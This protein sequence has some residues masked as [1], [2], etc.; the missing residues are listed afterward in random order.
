MK[1]K[2]EN[3]DLK[4]EWDYQRAKLLLELSAVGGEENL[5]AEQVKTLEKEVTLFLWREIKKQFPAIEKFCTDRKGQFNKC[6]KEHYNTP[7]ISIYGNFYMQLIAE[8]NKNAWVWESVE[9]EPYRFYFNETD[10][11]KKQVL[12]AM[13]NLIVNGEAKKSNFS[14]LIKAMDKETIKEEVIIL[15]LDGETMQV[16]LA[17]EIG[18]SSSYLP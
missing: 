10:Y 4:D 15:G 7:I 12:Q 3:L 13:K 6:S 9:L 18:N 5:T 8:N 17:N 1:V 14:K 2:V 11:F 16:G